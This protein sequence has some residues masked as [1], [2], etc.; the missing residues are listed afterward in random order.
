MR[1]TGRRYDHEKAQ[2]DPVGVDVAAA[3]TYNGWV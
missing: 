3:C 1:I 2:I